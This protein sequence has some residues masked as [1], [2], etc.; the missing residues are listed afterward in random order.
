MASSPSGMENAPAVWGLGP[1]QDGNPPSLAHVL[2]ANG[3]ISAPTVTIAL[4]DV[5]NNN[6]TSYGSLTLGGG[7][8]NTTTT[9]KFKP[10][11]NF[12]NAYNLDL[13][14]LKMPKFTIETAKATK[15]KS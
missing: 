3:V 14:G 11:K 12:K 1:T 5:F 15:G 4:N 6:L 2:N 9:D 13:W 7:P 10:H 8:A